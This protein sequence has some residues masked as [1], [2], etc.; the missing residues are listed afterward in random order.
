MLNLGVL[1]CVLNRNRTNLVGCI[2]FSRNCIL[3]EHRVEIYIYTA[4]FESDYLNK[5][6]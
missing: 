5:T 1:S 3:L 6:S 2:Q 4:C